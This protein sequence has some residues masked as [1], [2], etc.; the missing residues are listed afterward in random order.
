MDSNHRCTV[1]ETDRLPLSYSLIKLVPG[2]RFE[3]RFTPSEGVGLPV[4]RTGNR[5]LVPGLRFERRFN[6]SK[7]FVLPRVKRPRNSIATN[8][9]EGWNRTNIDRQGQP[10]LQTGE[11]SQFVHLLQ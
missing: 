9:A 5:K 1:L 7:P 4:N 8:G 6:G 11:L 2:L 10:V 3:H